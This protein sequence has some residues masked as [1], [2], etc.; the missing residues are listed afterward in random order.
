MDLGSNMLLFLRRPTLNVNNGQTVQFITLA[1]MAVGGHVILV[2]IAPG[3]FDSSEKIGYI[4]IFSSVS[5]R[6][7]G[8]GAGYL[9]VTLKHPLN[10]SLLTRKDNIA[11]RC[12]S[13]F[14]NLLNPTTSAATLLS[15]PSHISNIFANSSSSPYRRTREDKI[16]KRPRQPSNN[17]RIAKPLELN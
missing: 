9:L 14:Q 3:L 16:Y 8:G 15:Q 5:K 4:K 2:S 1:Q 12:M 10:M 7:R 13:H 11:E 6:A 17:S